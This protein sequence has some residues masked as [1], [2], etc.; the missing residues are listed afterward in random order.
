MLMDTLL[1]VSYQL[2]AKS[3]K[4]KKT[5]KLSAPSF[6]LRPFKIPLNPP[7]SK[8]DFKA[9]AFPPFVKGGQ[10]GFAFIF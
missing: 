1:F 7:F 8:G 3:K 9:W 2:S 5:L 6:Q 10:G 4:P